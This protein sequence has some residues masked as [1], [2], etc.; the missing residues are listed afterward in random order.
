MGTNAK[1]T[2]TP[3]A[4]TPAGGGEQGEA[5]EPV[6]EPWLPVADEPVPAEPGQLPVTPI[7]LTPDV[8][9]AYGEPVLVGGSD[10]LASTAT[11]VS[12]V[13]DQGPRTVLHARVDEDAEAK[14]LEAFDISSEMVPAQVEQQ[15]T[16]RLPIDEQHNVAETIISAAKSV[17]HHIATGTLTAGGEMP[18]TTAKK[19]AAAEAV[20]DELAEEL[21]D[22]SPTEEAMLEHYAAQFQA[23]QQAVA[24]CTPVEH[25]KP[26]VHDD[27][28]VAVV[29]A[30][31]SGAFGAVVAV[32][33]DATRIKPTLDD[34]TGQAS[35]AGARTTDVLGKEYAIDLGEG[36]RAVYR[37]YD[38]NDPAE[39]EYSLRGRLEVIAPAGEGHGPEVVRRLGQLNL[40]NRP[41]TRDEGEYSY[42]AANV[43]AQNLGAHAEVAAARVTGDHLE[44]MVRQEIFH[45][46]A[47]EAVGMS[48]LQLAGFAK[49]IQLEA[50]TR[51]LP[52]KVR[53]L[54]DAVA[55]ATGFTD[56][57]ALAASPG[58]D[59]APRRSAG[60]L[61]W[62]RF[63][64]GNATGK[65]KAAIAGRSLMHSTSFT[66][67]KAMLA[68]GV[69]ASTER[70][71]TMGTGPDIGKSEYSDKLTG[72]ASSVFLRVRDSSSLGGSPT[73]VWDQP[74]RLLARAD[75]YGANADTFGVIN[76]AKADEY[77]TVP[78]TRDP[79]E[80]AKFSS[81]S[82]EVMFGDGIDLLG[83]EGP[84]RILCENAAQ[85][86][87][88]KTFLNAKGVTTIAGKPIEEVVTL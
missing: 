85:R 16:G 38:I 15:V 52:A 44:E 10:L 82:N 20:I 13:S 7:P 12:Y 32:L 65:L 64:V 19:I 57:S 8:G 45:E 70:R 39:T 48:D 63:D 18:A 56:G 74:E 84:S 59:P 77:S 83:S 79:F 33:R 35:W 11:L 73:L 54:R 5:E 60:W 22:P 40:A 14:L 46:R 24:G 49:D 30:S 76:P 6:V 81:A 21:G 53:V 50:H 80:I 36:Y 27:T 2:H 51:A 87:E 17:N 37:P 1:T 78:S 42:L 68:T 88:I 72:G 25:A 3:Y 31:P 23:I 75:Y 4:L 9:H 43:T 69:L 34:T 29:P 58:Y 67:L 86:N 66:G 41:M 61:A 26:F 28:E 47:H 71:T 62:T 55:K